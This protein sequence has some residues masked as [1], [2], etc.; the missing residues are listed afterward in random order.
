[1]GLEPANI[2]GQELGWEATAAFRFFGRKRKDADLEQLWV[3]KSTGAE[4][5][6][7]IQFIHEGKKK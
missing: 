1:M 7:E 6:R 4:E 5:W 3:N 2:T